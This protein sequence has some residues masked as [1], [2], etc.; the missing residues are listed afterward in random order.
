[1][2]F[3]IS[4]EIIKATNYTEAEFR[5]EISILL[6]QKKKFSLGQAAK[7]TGLAKF[8]FQKELANR[9]IPVNYDVEE[10]RQDIQT[11]NSLSMI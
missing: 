9:K 6:Y 4:D 8:Q 3:L 10:L 7:F 5:L 2:S 1:M 11:L